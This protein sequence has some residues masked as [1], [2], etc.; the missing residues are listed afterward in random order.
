VDVSKRLS[1]SGYPQ[2]K[3]Q[4]T[5][6][7]SEIHFRRNWSGALVWREASTRGLNEPFALD[8]DI[9]TGRQHPQFANDFHL[10]R[11]SGLLRLFH[12]HLG[13]LASGSQTTD[14]ALTFGTGH[15]LLFVIVKLEGRKWD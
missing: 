7:P 14:F 9:G 15:E 11:G 10:G 13:F 3:T 4:A 12:Q 8:D 5:I 1:L 2:D 6:R